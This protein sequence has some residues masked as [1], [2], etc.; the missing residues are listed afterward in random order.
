MQPCPDGKPLNKRSSQP[1]ISPLGRDINV[2]MCRIVSADVSNSLEIFNVTEM[3]KLRRVCEATGEIPDDAAG[4]I[5]RNKKIF[6]VA[7]NI[8]PEPTLSK[9]LLFLDAGKVLLCARYK[10][11]IVYFSKVIGKINKFVC[12]E[13]CRRHLPSSFSWAFW[14]LEFFVKREEFE[15]DQDI[16]LSMPS[17]LRPA[18]V[19]CGPD[20]FCRSM[21]SIALSDAAIS[22]WQRTNR[23][24]RGRGRV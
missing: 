22:L 23:P 11:N 10:K 12:F 15:S 21:P 2:Q 19:A 13:Y 3:T 20:C 7:C 6:P 18:N 4:L 8:S 14:F 9:R 17:G 16:T 1:M 24:E 5:K